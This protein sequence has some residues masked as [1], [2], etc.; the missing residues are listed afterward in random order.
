VR[1]FAAGAQRVQ[2]TIFFGS[3]PPAGSPRPR[4]T[5]FRF[6]FVVVNNHEDRLPITFPFASLLLLLAGRPTSAVAAGETYRALPY[7]VAAAGAAARSLASAVVISDMAEGEDRASAGGR[8]VR[9]GGGTT[10]HRSLACL[11]AFSSFNAS[12]PDRKIGVGP[13]GPD[14]HLM[15]TTNPRTGLPAGF[16]WYG[17]DAATQP[18]I[19]CNRLYQQAFPGMVGYTFRAISNLYPKGLGTIPNQTINGCRAEGDFYV[20]FKLYDVANKKVVRR[21]K[22]E[23]APYVLYGN[24]VPVPAA[25][26]NFADY[27]SALLPNGLYQ[28][29]ATMHL[30][31][32]TQVDKTD[33]GANILVVS[34]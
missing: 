33:F 10:V 7:D 17:A 13:I 19:I 27:G 3:P 20:L 24:K 23:S 26:S 30:T 32:G 29:S 28:V 2:F 14:K 15:N 34:C 18:F 4:P 1:R 31:D 8:G 16:A 21:Q 22:E 5:L 11:P 6:A 9:G 25:N 12:D